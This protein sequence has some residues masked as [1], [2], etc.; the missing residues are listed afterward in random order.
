MRS[1]DIKDNHVNSILNNIEKEILSIDFSEMEVGGDENSF[2]ETG[3]WNGKKREYWLSEKYLKEVV[4]HGRIHDGYPESQPLYE[5]TDHYFAPPNRQSSTRI[6]ELKKNLME[7]LFVERDCLHAFYPPGSFCSW[8]NNANA[9][10]Y[11]IMFSWSETGDGYFMYRDPISKEIIQ[12]KDKK[13][14][15]AKTFY[16]G[17]YEEGPEKLVYHASSN[18]C[19]RYS[20]GFNV[21]EK[22]I[23]DETISLLES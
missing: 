12:I 10:G 22:F 20:M 4:D 23:M 17:S 1:F 6:L 13:G 21:Q 19:L 11:G 5:I 9:A 7:Y 15:N 14:W 2:L 8:H 3:L 16:F 18:E